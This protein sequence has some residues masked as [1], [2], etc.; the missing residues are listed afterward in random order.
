MT[1]LG[2]GLLI[3]VGRRVGASAL[4]GAL[5]AGL[6]ALG[7]GAA[8]AAVALAARTITVPERTGVPAAV[9]RGVV[10]AVLV[11]VVFAAVAYAADRTDVRPAAAALARRIRP[12][13]PATSKSAT[14]K[15]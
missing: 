7:A 2:A 4:A 3:A 15:E 13:T 11:V 14:S 9:L 5:R 10:G 1:V 6:V 12:R 8:G